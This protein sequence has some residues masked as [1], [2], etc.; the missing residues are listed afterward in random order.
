M[1]FLL[2]RVG[3]FRRKRQIEMNSFRLEWDFWD[4]KK[5]VIFCTSREF[6]ENI[7]SFSIV[8]DLK[9]IVCFVAF[10]TLQLKY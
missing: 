8:D 3:E 5:Y 7:I 2:F 6:S 10:L 1:V 9:V 4:H